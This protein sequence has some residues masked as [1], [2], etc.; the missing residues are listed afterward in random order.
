M[1]DPR[2]AGWLHQLWD[3]ITAVSVPLLVLGISFQTAQTLFVALAWRNILR[4]AYPEQGS[5]TA[6]SCA[7]TRAGSG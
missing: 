4:A 6:R 7:T 2:V 3:T 1:E 5:R